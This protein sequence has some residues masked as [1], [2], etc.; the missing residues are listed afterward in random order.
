L[1]SDARS[2]RERFENDDG[3]NTEKVQIG[4]RVPTVGSRLKDSAEL[5]GGVC[6]I[7][8]TRH[9]EARAN[10]PLGIG[11]SSVNQ[12]SGSHVAPCKDG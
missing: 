3:S 9:S 1:R 7:R 12:P 2:D 5:I 4:R 11:G 8:E 10:R 6:P